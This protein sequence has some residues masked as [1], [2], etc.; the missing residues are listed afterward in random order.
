MLS[1]IP[2]PVAVA[3]PE[4]PEVESVRRGL[5]D[6][7]T[8]RR[9]T[10]VAVHHP[11][12]VRDQDGGAPEF[13]GRLTGRRFTTPRRRGKF[14]WIPLADDGPDGNDT[15]GPEGLAMHL[16]MSGQIRVVEPT[17]AV[18]P[19]TR[20]V[21][22]LD[23]G[24]QVRVVDQR[25]FGRL[26]VDDLVPDPTADGRAVPAHA[27]HIAVDPLEPAFDARAFVDRLRSRRTTVKRA[28][29]DQTL[30]SGIGN[31]YADESLWRARVHGDRATHGLPVATARRLLA[32]VTDVLAEA[33][34]AGGTSFDA[35]YVDV[36]G[37]SGRHGAAL[38][39][40]G[41]AG[42]PCPRCGGAVSRAAFANRSSFWC[43]V[44]QRRP[45]AARPGGRHTA[46]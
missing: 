9:V 17:A 36:N 44:C 25:M 34:A 6:L 10:A 46:A 31:I 5:A 7:V 20:V 43:P 40:Y 33:V 45:S 41:R 18:H 30:V 22:E 2:L 42:L 12:L 38:A 35:L 16:G 23:D 27:A 4:L 14:L 1:A 21:L 19:H 32:H 29:L 26:R 28:L 37:E 13:A 3:V 11:R 8:G 24:R 15:P 39:V